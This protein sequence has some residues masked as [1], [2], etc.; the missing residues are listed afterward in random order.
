MLILQK[1]KNMSSRTLPADLYC[2]ILNCSIFSEIQKEINHII[3]YITVGR[4]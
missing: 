1:V 2:L 3:N 4:K